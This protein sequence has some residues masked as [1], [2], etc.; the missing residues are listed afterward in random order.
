M[1][2]VGLSRRLV[3]RFDDPVQCEGTEEA[4]YETDTHLREWLREVPDMAEQ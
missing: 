1:G 3:W 2:E 4:R